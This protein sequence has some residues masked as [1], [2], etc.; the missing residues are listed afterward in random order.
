MFHISADVLST[1]HLFRT[2]VMYILASLV[3]KPVERN[4]DQLK[5]SSESRFVTA[6]ASP[7]KLI[8]IT[9]FLKS[10]K[11]ETKPAKATLRNVTY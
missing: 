2:P 11:S 7:C 4:D 1:T 9:R 8:G 6:T 5:M 3:D 10:A